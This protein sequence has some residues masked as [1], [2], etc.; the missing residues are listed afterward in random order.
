MGPGPLI[1]F[2]D[3]LL[4]TQTTAKQIECEAKGMKASQPP[5]RVYVD[6][7][8][9]PPLGKGMNAF[10]NHLFADTITC[11]DQALAALV[12]SADT[13]RLREAWK[14]KGKALGGLKRYEEE[15][16]CYERG[17]EIDP[18]DCELWFRKADVLDDLGRLEEAVPCYDRA[19][20][21]DSMPYRNSLN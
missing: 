3:E 13:Y 2:V 9:C 1:R 11:C 6:D 18:N 10:Q 16:L 19:L 21:L 8:K 5:F 7:P 4:Q 17:I 14:W 20:A 12:G 15:L